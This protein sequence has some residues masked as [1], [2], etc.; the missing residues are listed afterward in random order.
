M[1]GP[2]ALNDCVHERKACPFADNCPVQK[3]WV[4]VS[5]ELAKKL[6]SIRFDALVNASDGHAA[7]HAALKVNA[8]RR[9]TKPRSNR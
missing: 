7:A 1:E 3:A 4:E 6:A 9:S 8:A 2:I 5:A